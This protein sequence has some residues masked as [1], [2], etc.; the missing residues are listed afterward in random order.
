VVWL[1]L[2][3]W[4]PASPVVG[5]PR[6]RCRQPLPR[7]PPLGFAINNLT[8][9]ASLLSGTVVDDATWG[10]RKMS[11]A[12]FATAEPAR[13][14]ACAPCEEVRWRKGFRYALV[15]CAVCSMT[16]HAV[17][18]A[19]LGQFF[20]EIRIT[21]AVGRSRALHASVLMTRRRRGVANPEG[22]RKRNGQLNDGNPIGAAGRST[23]RFQSAAFDWR[24]SPYADART[25]TP[26]IRHTH[27][28]GDA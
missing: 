23:A 19:I 6:Y 8:R 17:S 7:W 4:R 10:G 14:R 9:S 25:P 22:D 3:G 18:A 11:S 27:A 24:P 5:D 21:I 15:S 12:T 13:R 1:V 28:D 16:N 26:G 20:S 2:Q